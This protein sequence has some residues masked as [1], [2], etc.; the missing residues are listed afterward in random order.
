MYIEIL[1]GLRSHYEKRL[2]DKGSAGYHAA[3]SMSFLFGLSAAAIFIIVDA[4]R[5]RRL[6][7][8]MWLYDHKVWLVVFGIVT[9]WAHVQY[10]KTKHVYDKTGPPMSSLW[11]PWFIGYCI[12]AAL[13]IVC[14]LWLTYQARVSG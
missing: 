3:M 11:R 9:A 7:G 1:D 5:S 8:L 2:K 6:H 13:L 14:A 12:F 4:F 10:A